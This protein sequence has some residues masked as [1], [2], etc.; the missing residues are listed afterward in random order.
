VK[1]NVVFLDDIDKRN[2]PRTRG[3][4]Q[5]SENSWGIK[6]IFQGSNTNSG[7]D[8]FYPGDGNWNDEYENTLF[9]QIHKIKPKY[10]DYNGN[11]IENDIDFIY[12]PVLLIPESIQIKKYAA[13]ST[14]LNIEN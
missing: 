11:Q 1:V 2:E 14:N 4:F 13:R 12:V 9:L 5:I 10:M 6:Q 7:E 8:K 3:C